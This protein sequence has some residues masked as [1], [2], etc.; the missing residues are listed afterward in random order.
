MSYKVYLP[1]GIW[2]WATIPAQE[3]VQPQ[4]RFPWLLRQRLWCSGLQKVP[5]SATLPGTCPVSISDLSASPPQALPSWGQ[6]WEVGDRPCQERWRQWKTESFLPHDTQKTD[7]DPLR[8]WL[9][10]WAA[11]W[12]RWPSQAPPNLNHFMTMFLWNN[13]HAV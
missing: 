11:H 9:L 13:F 8:I 3:Q 2:H 1:E 6:S 5:G 4:G 12:T 10:L 7:P